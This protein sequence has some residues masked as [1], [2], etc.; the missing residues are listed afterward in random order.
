M[1]NLKIRKRSETLYSL[2][3]CILVFM[4]MMEATSLKNFNDSWLHDILQLM[5]LAIALFYIIIK[6]YTIKELVSIFLLNLVGILC[7][8]SSGY[9]GLLMTMLAITLLPKGSLDEILHMILVEETVV[10]FFIVIMSQ[11]GVLSNQVFAINKGS[12]TVLAKT[13]GF[14]HPNMLAAQA[15]SILLLYLCVNRNRVKKKHI[16]FAFLSAI[17]IFYFS[18]GR[19]SF[20]LGVM[21]IISIALQKKG[22]FKKFVFTILPWMYCIV[23][24]MLVGCMFAYANFGEKNP[25]VIALNDGLFNGRVGLA[26][27]SLVVYP[28]TLFGKGIDTSIWNQWQYYSLDNGQVMVLLEYGIAGFICY[29]VIIQKTLNQIK[30]ENEIVFAIVISIFLIWSMYEGTMYFI[31]K[32]FA[33]LFLGKIQFSS[34]RR[35]V[36]D[37]RYDSHDS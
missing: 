15:M 9:S 37:E 28:I 1:T 5:A 35:K 2:Y 25:I 34:T 12:Y 3:I 29:F 21:A 13:F 6:K 19:T 8:I 10:F 33:L 4:C 30:K 11:I 27:R 20:I 26:Y 22:K 24:C 32:N 7:F 36:L 18:K 31:G 16:A 17:V 14:E 23:L